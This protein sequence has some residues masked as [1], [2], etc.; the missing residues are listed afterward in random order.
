MI[1]IQRY[2]NCWLL[3]RRIRHHWLAL[4]QIF[5]VSE[6]FKYLFLLFLRVLILLFNFWHALFWLRK[7]LE[8]NLL[9]KRLPLDWHTPFGYFVVFLTEAGA[10]VATFLCV[11]SVICFLIG[12]CLLFIHFV[13]DIADDLPALNVNE[14]SDSNYMEVKKRFC[15]II[16]SYTDVTK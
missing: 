7:K 13:K 3:R 11:A 12:S 6:F 2:I 5:F 4:G 16:Q 9:Y 8:I 10:S 1:A 14:P 15:D